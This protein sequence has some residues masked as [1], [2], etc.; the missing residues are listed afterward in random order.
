MEPLLKLLEGKKK[1]KANESKSKVAIV[2]VYFF[3]CIEME[4]Y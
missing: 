4:K 2:W 1:K 3:S